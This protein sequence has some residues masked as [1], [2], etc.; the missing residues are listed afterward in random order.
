MQRRLPKRG[1]RNPLA[2]LVA[3]V[4][5]GDLELFDVGAVVDAQALRQARLVQG[6]VDV[7]KVLGDGDLT[8][9]L[10]V[11]AH[12][13]SR[14]AVAKIE[15]AGGKAITLPAPTRRATDAA[16]AGEAAP[17]KTAKAKTPKAK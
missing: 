4:N 10:T 3:A 14:G 7:I 8:K 13:F 11:S 15:A 1:F 6:R 2:D 9:K 5:V 12:R 17:A 16:E